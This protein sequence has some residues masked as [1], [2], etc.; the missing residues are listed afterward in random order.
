MCQESHSVGEISSLE[1]PELQLKW[2]L[3]LDL[4]SLQLQMVTNQFDCVFAKL[5][6]YFF[7]PKSMLLVKQLLLFTVR[8]TISM[9]TG[10]YEEYN[11]VPELICSKLLYPIS[12]KLKKIDCFYKTEKN[13]QLLFPFK[14]ENPS[15]NLCCL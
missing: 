6:N 5:F 11:R 10:E 14:L 7:G 8:A 3:L 13:K 12:G 4:V 9:V 2:S 15:L 1:D